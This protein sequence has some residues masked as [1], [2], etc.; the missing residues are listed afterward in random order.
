MSR[1]D[2]QERLAQAGFRLNDSELV[3]WYGQDDEDED[4]DE[5]GARVFFFT[6]KKRPFKQFS[7]DARGSGG[8]SSLD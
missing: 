5:R 3:P 2:L 1:Q 4:E 6:S 8:N 7:P